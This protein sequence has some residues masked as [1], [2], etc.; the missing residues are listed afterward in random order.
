M[1]SVIA[2]IVFFMTDGIACSQNLVPNGGFEELNDCPNNGGQ[3]Q[4]TTHWFRG[5]VS[6]PDLFNICDGMDT[7]GVPRNIF[8]YQFPA[9]GDG[10]CGMW[11]FSNASL[12]GYGTHEIIGV[13]LSLPLTPGQTYWASFRISWTSSFPSPEIRTRYATDKMG[14]LMRMDSVFE[15]WDWQPWPDH[16]HIFTEAVISDSL[17]W[18]QISGQFNAD[19]AYSFLYLGNFFGDDQTEA[20]L[21]DPD[22][23][24]D[25][26]YYYVDDVC[27]STDPLD[28]DI[29]IGSSEVPI[30]PDIRAWIGQGGVIHLD[31]LS[32]QVPIHAMVYDS[33]GRTVL[34]WTGGLDNGIFSGIGFPSPGTYFLRLIMERSARTFRLIAPNQ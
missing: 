5:G 34:S 1:R 13:R 12:P 6:S 4:K 31:G 30:L 18:T 29:H 8:G 28:C 20:I 17:G 14:V 9:S 11:A 26:S 10:Y 33:S 21:V 23:N 27:L 3:L 32:A 24:T 22:G 19:S 7:C 15:V 16:A 2:F 25:I